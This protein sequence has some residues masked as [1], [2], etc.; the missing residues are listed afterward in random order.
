MQHHR[1]FIT[2]FCMVCALFFSLP[3][4]ALAKNECVVLL[5]G[6]ARVSNS[7]G[8]LET[9]LTRSGYYVVNINYP[10]RRYEL[11]LLAADAVS[12]GLAECYNQGAESI[13]FVTHS[14]G[15]ILVRQYFQQ[16]SNP[17]L[18][19]V[20]ML[21]PPNQGSEIVDGLSP[22]P[23]FEL[24]WGPTGVML[25][26][27]PG[28]ILH[29]LGPVKFELGVIAGTTNINPLNLFLMDG[30]NDSIVTVASTRVEGMS[31]HIVLPVTHTF[32]MRNNEVIDH[33]IHFLKTGSFMPEQ[34][35]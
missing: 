15:G 19:R 5:H 20:V 24:L 2:R 25:G 7:M 29:D 21:G 4:G 32:M 23:G 10:S 26:T 3:A 13:H 8:E 9:K 11:E 34:A 22:I 14:L 17:L 1:Q 30:P 35:Q 27:G 16:Q 31:A 12:R 6:L 33:T 28:S 18:G